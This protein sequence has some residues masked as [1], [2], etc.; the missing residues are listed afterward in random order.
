MRKLNFPIFNPTG[1]NNQIV[2]RLM[3]NILVFI[4]LNICEYY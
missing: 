3:L 2:K 4:G 1:S